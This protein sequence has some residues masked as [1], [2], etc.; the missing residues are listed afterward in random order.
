MKHTIIML[1]AVL[2]LT[3]CN[4]TS[5]AQIKMYKCTSVQSGI[6]TQ[7][8]DT[9]T[10]TET[11]YFNVKTGALNNYTTNK[12]AFYFTSDT[13]SGTPVTCYVVAQGSYD[14]TTWFNLSGSP[15][16]TDGINCDSLALVAAS[17]VGTQSKLYEIGGT[18]K[19]SVTGA[20]AAGANYNHTPR[21]PYIRLKFV[22]PS[23]TV[24]QVIS[25]VFCIPF[26]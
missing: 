5:N 2:A 12:Y 15:L 16:G 26:N 7:L 6:T 21:V 4:K 11:T 3:A 20:P 17:Q 22:Q 24:A 8:T 1:L 10:N 9:L 18:T 13:T 25:G 19:W 23:G 14:G